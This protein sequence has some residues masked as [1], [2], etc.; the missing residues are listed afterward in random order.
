MS[1]WAFITV[2]NYN[3]KMT[4][5][6]KLY[7]KVSTTHLLNGSF[8]VVVVVGLQHIKNLAADISR[9]GSYSHLKNIL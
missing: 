5:L 1:Q 9:T 2:H 4:I 8:S 3:I 6:N 7:K